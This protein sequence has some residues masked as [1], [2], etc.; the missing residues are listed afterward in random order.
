MFW[1]KPKIEDEKIIKLIK[2]RPDFPFSKNE[3]KF[4]LLSSLPSQE[5]AI[6]PAKWLGVPRYAFA[7]GFLILAIS[8]TSTLA[9][10]DAAKPGDKLFALDRW[11]EDLALKL[12]P[13]AQTKAKLQTK[14]VTERAKELTQ[15]AQ[16][17]NHQEQKI[18]AVHQSVR[19]LNQAIESVSKT[20]NRMRTEG[21]DKSAARLDTVL[22]NLQDLAETHE[23]KT[24]EI[25]MRID[26]EELKIRIDE[27]LDEIRQAKIKVRLE[28]RQELQENDD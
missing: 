26:D 23:Q 8:L 4:K 20:R 2:S 22:N 25:R 3:I 16:T 27:N 18:E 13:S 6:T 10:A 24:N 14:F 9:Y 12:T 5:K 28:L 11:Q 21:K 17:T 7:S 15:L 1:L 19:S